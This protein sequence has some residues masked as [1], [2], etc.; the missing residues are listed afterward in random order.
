MTAMTRSA[1][2]TPEVISS[3][4]PDASL[5]VRSGTLRT[6]MAS[7]TPVLL[8]H[9]GSRF[10]HDG[11]PD[12]VQR[13]YDGPAAAALDEPAGGLGLGRHAPA[14]ELAPL[15]VLPHLLDPDPAERSRG[16]AGVSDVGVRHVGGD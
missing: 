6:S 13:G 14:A 11:F 16:A 12:P 7:G 10:P 8:L 4:S 3:S 1:S 2:M 15:Q 5:T 9:D